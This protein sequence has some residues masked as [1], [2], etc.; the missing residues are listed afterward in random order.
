MPLHHTHV[1]IVARVVPTLY[2]ACSERSPVFCSGFF[3]CKCKLC[4]L[5]IL[6]VTECCSSCAG[7]CLEGMCHAA[8][9]CPDA[10]MPSMCGLLSVIPG[11]CTQTHALM[12]LQQ[13]LPFKAVGACMQLPTQLTGVHQKLPFNSAY[14]H[15]LLLLCFAFELVGAKT[16]SC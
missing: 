1:C 13:Q 6:F 7:S 10:A 14:V 2:I 5:R 9:T 4:P 3:M 8:V 12:D 11:M 15:K 16:A